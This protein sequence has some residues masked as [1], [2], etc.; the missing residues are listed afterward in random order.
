MICQLPVKMGAKYNGESVV[1]PARQE[2]ADLLNQYF[3]EN[4]GPV[5]ASALNLCDDPSVL[6]FDI[7]GLTATEPNIQVMGGLMEE[8]DDAQHNNNLD[9]SNVVTD[10]MENDPNTAASSEST[11]GADS[12]ESSS[13]EEEPAA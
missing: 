11:D 12:G 5:D 8:A 3:R 2:D 9:G 13:G 4:T 1:Y 6:G 7:S 10:I